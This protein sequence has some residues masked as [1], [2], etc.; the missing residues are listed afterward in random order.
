[1]L[2]LGTQVPVQ[3]QQVTY[4]QPSWKFGVAVGANANYYQ[5]TTQ[6]LNEGRL[7]LQPFGHGNGFGLFTALTLEYHRPKSWLGF[8]LQGGFDSRRGVFD[9]VLSPCNC[10]LD[11]STGLSYL[12]V[13][14]SLKL[15]PF[16]SN[17]YIFGGPRFAFLRS[18]SFEYEQQDNPDFRLS[19]L[20]A[21]NF[22]PIF[23]GQVNIN[24][25]QIDIPARQ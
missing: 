25:E 1:M 10:P 23:T 5:G 15:A 18:K 6:L 24:D 21:R 20:F 12:T 11:L 17:F 2:L 8:M 14:P 16:R 22:Q 13:E 19:T 3:A 4:E 7:S 9:Q